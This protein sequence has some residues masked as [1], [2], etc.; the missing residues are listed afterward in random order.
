MG[1]HSPRPKPLEH[2]HVIQV[3]GTPNMRTCCLPATAGLDRTRLHGTGHDHTAM[4]VT[5][6]VPAVVA[7]VTGPS[8]R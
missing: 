2:G 4:P 8:S 5:N 1:S 7:A 3:F 6:A